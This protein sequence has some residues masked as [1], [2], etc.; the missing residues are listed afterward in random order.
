MMCRDV[1]QVLLFDAERS[2]EIRDVGGVH[3]TG[4]LMPWIATRR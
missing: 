4:R 2:A 1:G 3:P